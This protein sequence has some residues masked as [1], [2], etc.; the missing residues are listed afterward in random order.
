[1]ESWYNAYVIQQ[2]R[3]QEL[4]AEGEKERLAGALQIREGAK[5]NRLTQGLL[6]LIGLGVIVV[7]L[8]PASS[9]SG[10]RRPR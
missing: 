9:T 6:G 3:H 1:M 2:R 8:R 7:T 10:A 5:V 4:L